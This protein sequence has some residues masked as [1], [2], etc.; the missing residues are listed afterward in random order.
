MFDA[1][2]RPLIDPPLDALGRR[3]AAA[4]L[5][6]NAIT[7]L[8]LGLGLAAAV[9]IALDALLVGLVLLLAN[10]LADGLD[11]AVARATRRTDLG[12]YLDI[13]CDFIFYGAIPLAFALRD[14]DGTALAAAVLLFSFYANGAA[15]LT[16]AIMAERRRLQTSRQGLKS[17]Y[18]LGGLAEG[19]ETIAVFALMCVLPQHVALIA[20]GFAA[21][22][23]VSA[24]ARMATALVLLRA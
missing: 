16:F 15:F 6:A 2:I 20:Y 5:S 13:V 9:A 12:G 21:L 22:C 17:L 23:L 4:G 18:Y 7:V 19:A 3:L 11:G 10:R 1:R 24:V 14:P 8:G